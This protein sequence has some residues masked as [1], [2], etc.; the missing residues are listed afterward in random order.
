MKVLIFDIY[1]RFAHFRKFYTNSSSLTYGIPPRTTVAGIVAAIMGYERDS[2]YEKFSSDKLRL[3]IK[4]I[5]KTTKL[6]QTL[7]YTRATSMGELVKGVGPTQV[8]FEVLN[9][10]QGVKFRIYLTY[11]DDLIFHEI[12]RRVREG[13]FI[14][15]PYLGSASFGC[16]IS[17]IDTLEFEEIKSKEYINIEGVIRADFIEDIN[18]KNYNGTLIKERIP[19]D[20]SK[21]RN[22]IDVSSYVYDDEGKSLEIKINE[23][24]IKISNGEHIIFM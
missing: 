9:S 5:N 21:E 15:P 10:F 1:G 20:F 11:D 8:P 22:I 12:E 2:Y 3:A 4:K 13:L 7:N 19:V 14:Y 23:R 17:Y 24:I 16:N 18:L 6:I